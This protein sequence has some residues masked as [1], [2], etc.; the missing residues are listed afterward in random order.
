MTSMRTSTVSFPALL[1]LTFA[2]TVQ[3]GCKRPPAAPAELDQLCAYL[4]THFDDE[5][6]AAL[7]VGID[8]LEAWLDLSLEETLEGYEVSVLEQSAV[9][10]L[11]DV[12]RDL[13]GV[14]GAA[15]GYESHNSVMDQTY[16][17]VIADQVAV[18][19]GTYSEYTR[20]FLS[21]EECFMSQECDTA[22]MLNSGVADYPFSLEITSSS[23]GDFRWVERGGSTFSTGEYSL[24]HRTYLTGPAE[25]NVDWVQ[26]REQYYLDIVMP[27]DD[28]ALKLQATWFVAELG[29]APLPENMALQLVIGSMQDSGGKIDDWIDENL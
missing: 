28:G 13:S 6:P 14:V 17:L 23:W 18:F 15:V 12:D 3:T 11:D 19:E 4:F 8:N 20:E 21:D 2:M 16:A 7:E 10:A 25:V 26:V 9:D 24:A 22:R 5:D 27:R 29:D 1:T